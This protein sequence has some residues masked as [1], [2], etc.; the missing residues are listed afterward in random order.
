MT[1][2]NLSTFVERDASGA[3]DLDTTMTKFQGALLQ[4]QAERETELETIGTAVNAVFDEH[5]GATINMP[6][7]TTLALQKLNVQPESYKALSERVQSFVRDNASDER[8][9]GGTF[10]IAKGKGGG[11]SRWVDVADKPAKK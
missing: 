4:Y 6:A 9:G 5:R 7:V 10:R 8:N 11:V 3:L 1:T 2:I